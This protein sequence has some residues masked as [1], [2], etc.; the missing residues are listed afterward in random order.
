MTTPKLLLAFVVSLSLT[1]ALAPRVSALN[2]TIE[3]VDGS[4]VR[5]GNYNSIALDPSGLPHIAYFDFDYQTLRYA[6]RLPSGTW[7]IEFPDPQLGGS[8]VGQT[9]SIAVDSS[10]RPHIS[11]H[12]LANK[13]LKYVTKSTSGTWHTETVDSGADTGYGTSIALDSSGLPHITYHDVS[14]SGDLKYARK[15]CKGP[16]GGFPPRRICAWSIE[17]VDPGWTGKSS[18]ALDS[19]G[20]PHIIYAYSVFPVEQ[21]IKY[22]NK[23]TSGWVIEIVGS[24]YW[25]GRSPSMALDSGGLPHIS[26][27]DMAN[28]DLTYARKLASGGWSLQIVD[29]MGDGEA[30]PES[31]SSIAVDSRGLPHI[32][33]YD[34]SND[35]LKYAR[36]LCYT[37]S[38]GGRPVCSWSTHTVEAAGVSGPF[39]YT[40]IAL[41]ANGLPHISYWANPQDLKYA[42]EFRGK[43]VSPQEVL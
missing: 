33:Y 23:S 31:V 38:W 6:K 22:A 18:I 27:Y 7:Q 35:D 20:V 43:F 14:L 42:K 40:S 13:D 9:P 37:P 11:Y 26:Y 3:L 41:D 4:S 19:N 21:G 39:A 2:W 16:V 1:L 34:V 8:S 17:I 36:K 32:S 24:G 28:Q 12:D 5:V 29:S 30:G 25:A 10:G 15:Y